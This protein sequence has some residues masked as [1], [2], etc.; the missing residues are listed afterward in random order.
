MLH[1]MYDAL[2]LQKIMGAYIVFYSHSKKKQWE[3]PSNFAPDVQKDWHAI[4]CQLIP[5]LYGDFSQKRTTIEVGLAI[6]IIFRI[7][8]S[9]QAK[10][11][12]TRR[13][14]WEKLYLLSSDQEIS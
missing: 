13:S 11:R 7:K 2:T 5:E 4:L 8:S 3:H 6:G 9:N 12:E 1:P 14:R 10:S